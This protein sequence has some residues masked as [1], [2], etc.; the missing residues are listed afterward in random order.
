MSTCPDSATRQRRRRAA[1][2]DRLALEAEF[3]NEAQHHRV[4][5]RAVGRIGDRGCVGGVL[6]GLERRVRLDEPEVGVAG[7]AARD[8]ADRRAFGKSAERAQRADADPDVGAA[9]DHRLLGFAGALGTDRFDRDAMPGEDAGAVAQLD[10]RRIPVAALADGDLQ[11]ISS[12][13]RR[14]TGR[15]GSKRHRNAGY[16]PHPHGNLPALFIAA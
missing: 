7:R 4:G 5:G 6:D 16:E 13:C 2:R 9:G 8:D 12:R 10:R 14:A 15:N 11:H 1:G 3:A